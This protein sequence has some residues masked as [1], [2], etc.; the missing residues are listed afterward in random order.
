MSVYEHSYR[1]YAGRTTPER[2]RFLVIP[3][4]AY[5]D[6]FQSKLFIAFYAL[7]FAYPL[8]SAIL[9]YL[10]HNTNAIA[11]LKI[12]LNELVP[13][14]ASFFQYFIEVQGMCA[15]FI[16][17]LVGP[18]LISRDLSNNAL[19]LYLCRPFS[20]GEYVVGKMSVVMILLSLI[21]WVP[22]LLLFLFQSYLEGAGWM[23][24]NLQ[25]AFAIFVGSI[26]WII[27]L[28]LLSQAV[29]AW[30]KWRVIAS[31]ALL[32]IFFIPSAFGE[33]INQ[34]FLTRWGNL[35]SLRAIIYAI[36]R[37]LFG[38]FERQTGHIE[39]RITGG[40][41]DTHG[42]I[43]DIILLEPPLWCFWI[44]LALVCAACLWLLFRKVRAYEVVKT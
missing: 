19:P 25:I 28:A 26:V 21:T 32:G 27:T 34:L 44:A 12:D 3:R 8:V 22:G 5:R 41:H 10:H 35:L 29:S 18:P 13:I 37:G 7:C 43:I 1:R 2:S 4:Y 38:H 15:F 23:F 36:W 42:R 9:I 40:M 24:S 6:V 20:R 30:V 33:V 39:G 16:N 31:A 17:L 11:L 14:K